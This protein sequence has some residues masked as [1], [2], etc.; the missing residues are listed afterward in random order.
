MAR[1]DFAALK[2]R[3]TIEQACAL[4]GI[5][6]KKTGDQLRGPCPICSHDSPRAFV[7]TPKLGLYWCFGHCA[8]GGDC[9]EL[10]ARAR[11]LSK[12]EAARLL[13]DHFGSS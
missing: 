8:S 7:V 3:V 1:I 13:A 4:L 10:V 12:R 9:I 11:Q 2:R 5:P 6:L